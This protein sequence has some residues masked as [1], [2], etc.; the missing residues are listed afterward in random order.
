MMVRA[1]EL[2]ISKVKKREFSFDSKIS[3]RY[4][5]FLVR[6]KIVSSIRG[7]FV[8]QEFCFI[9]RCCNIISVRNIKLGNGVTIGRYCTLDAVSECG[10]TLGNN[11]NLGDFSVVKVSGSVRCLGKFIRLGNNVAI[12]EY[13]YLGGAGGL[14]IGDDTII[15][16]YFSCHPENHNYSDPSVLIRDQG[17][18]RQGIY[19]GSNC[20][21][22]SKVTILDG[23]M[24]GN[25]CIVAAGAVVKGVFPDNVIIGGVPAR[26]IKSR[27]E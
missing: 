15:G 25:G 4:I 17:V 22:G 21:I 13:S 1:I 23:A 6:N 8:F 16:Q 2:L 5:V 26:I 18:S 14:Q 12:G 3:M 27:Y 7:F 20:W 9:G 24:I 19:I 11:F 10:I